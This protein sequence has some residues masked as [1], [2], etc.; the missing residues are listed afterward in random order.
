MALSASVSLGGDPTHNSV[1]SIQS[2]WTVV[3]D[4]ANATADTSTIVTAFA[5]AGGKWV[6]VGHPVTKIKLRL[7]HTI[8]DAT[9]TAPIV[10]IWATSAPLTSALVPATFDQVQLI[11][12][13]LTLGIVP[14]HD[15][16]V[17]DYCAA[18][19]AFDLDAASAFLI[20]V[21]TAGVG[22]AVAHIQAK[23][24]N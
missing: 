21:T 17:Y 20:Q 4:N 8:D 12:S 14:T 24:L 5:Q 3:H 1:G 19:D 15:D 9:N 10:S 7:R 22:S 18:S 6:R 23:T 16:T 11:T 13:A 2:G